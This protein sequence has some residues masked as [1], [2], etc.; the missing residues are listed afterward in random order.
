[1]NEDNQ[2]LGTIDDL[3]KI[4]FAWL[5][6]LFHSLQYFIS[7]RHR[8][9]RQGRT[10]PMCPGPCG[11]PRALRTPPGTADPSGTADPLHLLGEQRV[12]S[13]IHI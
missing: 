13:L 1:M 2:T 10:V 9:S 5:S 3:L 4:L 8:L 11:P 12:S 7:Q 6:Y